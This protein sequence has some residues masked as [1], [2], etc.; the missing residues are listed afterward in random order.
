MAVQKSLSREPSFHY[1]INEKFYRY[2]SNETCYLTSTDDK[3]AISEEDIQTIV[4]ICNE[5]EVFKLFGHIEKFKEGYTEEHARGFIQKAQE[6]WKNGEK[7]TFL[8]RNA[9]GK[10]VAAAD[11]K[12]NN[13]DDAEIGYWA[14]AGYP[15][16]MSNAVIALCNAAKK[17]G[18][19][20]LHTLVREENVKS[21]KVSINAGLIET[22]TVKKK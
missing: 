12:S 2:L 22:G 13:V 20:H 4:G 21:I 3:T 10:I 6:G 15:G 16:I 5:P 9:D 11:I 1:P 7:F 17:S 19:K 14:T 18:F 8:I